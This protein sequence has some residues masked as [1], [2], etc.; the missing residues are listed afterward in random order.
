MQ[1]LTNIVWQPSIG[2][3]YTS[4]SPLVD[5][6]S[7]AR[8][9]S[10]MDSQGNAVFFLPKRPPYLKRTFKGDPLI[11]DDLVM[12]DH[13]NKPVRNYPGA[14]LTLDSRERAFVLDGLRRTLGMTVRE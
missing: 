4:F 6:W 14:P 11:F 5:S 2:L 9:D 8:L 7:E 3:N 13:K 12:L 1:T 10:V